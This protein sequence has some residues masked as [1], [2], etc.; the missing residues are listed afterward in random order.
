M[1]VDMI[2]HFISAAGI[3]FCLGD[4]FPNQ[5]ESK[6]IAMAWE[7]TLQWMSV[8]TFGVGILLVVFS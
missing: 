5:W 8:D 4:R 3:Y 6:C 7:N 2:K 1:L